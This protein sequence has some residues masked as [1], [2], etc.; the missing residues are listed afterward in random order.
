MQARDVHRLTWRKRDAGG[1]ALDDCGDWWIIF[2]HRVLP[3]GRHFQSSKDYWELSQ[4]LNAL[5]Q[6]LAEWYELE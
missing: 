6:M 1:V 3:D 5:T 4:A 2:D